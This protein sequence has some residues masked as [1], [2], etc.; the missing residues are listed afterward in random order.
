MPFKKCPTFP[1]QQISIISPALD[2]LRGLVCGMLVQTFPQVVADQALVIALPVNEV[3]RND[4]E[5]KY[6]YVVTWNE[7]LAQTCELQ[8]R[9]P[10]QSILQ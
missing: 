8:R 1:V 10:A 5:V 7:N 6:V 2:L 9:R 3:G 4:D